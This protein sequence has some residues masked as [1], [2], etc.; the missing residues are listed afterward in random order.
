MIRILIFLLS[1]VFFAF[2]ITYVASL[3]SRISGEAF[4]YRFDS[5]SGFVLGLLLLLFAGAIYGTAMVKDIAAWPKKLRQQQAEAKRSRG[6]AA[7]T[8]GLEAVAVGDAEDAMHH[9]RVAKRNLDDA[10][11]TRLLTAQAAHLSGDEVAAKESFSAMLKAP[12]TEFLG[13]KGLYAQAA[14]AG[15]R[16][17]A[18]EYADR[19]FQLRPNAAWAFESVFEL[20]LERGAWGETR[21]ALEKARKNKLLEPEK[22][23]RAAAVLLAA[24]AYAADAAGDAE[25]ALKDSEAALKLAAGFAP[26]ATLAASLLSVRGKTGKAVKI[27]ENAFRSA[28]HPGLSAAYDR[29]LAVESDA[30][31][32][33]KLVR[34][35][36]LVDDE[37]EKRLLRA[38]AAMLT[39][40]HRKAVD[41]IEPLLRSSPTANVYSI[42]ASAIAELH[43]RDAAQPWLERAARAPRDPRPG[44]DGAFHFTRNGWARLVR[45]YMEYGRLAPPPLEESSLAMT[46]EEIRLLIAP[47]KAETSTGDGEHA[48]ADA[49]AAVVSD[50][51]KQEDDEKAET[52]SPVKSADV[53]RQNA[54]NFNDVD[55][56]AS[57]AVVVGDDG[58]EQAAS[59]GAAPT[60]PA[61]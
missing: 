13:L 8:R 1:I 3:D 18:R 41:E 47:P 33:E 54:D 16:A 43:G 26:A 11:L 39:G 61:S 58:P 51:V 29:L 35:A 38:R 57:D 37:N 50:P 7:L 12:E 56:T 9:A 31:R 14:K 21:A 2:T 30:R 60:N 6:I 5:S 34:F 4:G 24:D 52:A 40:D 36:E 20:G 22:A 53:K 17:L 55:N 27:I 44:A 49:T 45:E 23:D 42:M 19:A 25:A 28:P 32:A 15:D 48:A 46:A 59:T 10:A